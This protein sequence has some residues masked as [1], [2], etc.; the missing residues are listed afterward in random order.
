MVGAEAREG[1]GVSARIEHHSDLNGGERSVS[2]RAKLDANTALWRGIARQQVFLACVDQAHRLAQAGC[3]GGCQRLQQGFLAAKS[4]TDV[5]RLDM[6]L[7]LRQRER[8]GNRRAHIEQSLRAGPDNQVM[9][10]R[11]R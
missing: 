11:T 9:V 3:N 1:I 10:G 7:P 2:L 6:N 5:Y 4:S 8:P